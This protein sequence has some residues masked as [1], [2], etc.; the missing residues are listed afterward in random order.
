V[1]VEL[2]ETNY[3]ALYVPEDFAHGFQT[4]E[5]ESEVF[6]HMFEFYS[7]EHARGVRWDDPAFGLTWPLPNPTIS[8]RD[9]SYAPYR[10]TTG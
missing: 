4:L 6:Y 7:R 3:R 9:K 2:S 10:R 1:A 8:E 5:D